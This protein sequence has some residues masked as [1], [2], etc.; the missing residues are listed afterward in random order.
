MRFPRLLVVAL[1][2]LAGCGRLGPDGAIGGTP[3]APTRTEDGEV[4]L[5]VVRG[6]L[7]GLKAPVLLPP[8]PTRFLLHHDPDGDE[9]EE[10]EGQ[11]PPVAAVW[12]RGRGAARHL[13]PSSGTAPVRIDSQELWEVDLRPGIYEL[14]LTA[15]A[16]PLGSIGPP[17][18]VVVR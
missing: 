17:V 5:R 2:S 1:V 8:G 14:S 4:L 15:G 7:V 10:A 9:I 11:D 3:R 12:I 18:V 6:R 13:L 16:Q